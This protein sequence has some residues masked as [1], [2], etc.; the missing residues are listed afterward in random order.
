MPNAM[1][2][3]KIYQSLDFLGNRLLNVKVNTPN[4]TKNSKDFQKPEYEEEKDFV[5][6]KE[7]VDKVNTYDSPLVT[8]HKSS[9]IFKWVQNIDNLTI[10]EVLEK[11]LFPKQTALYEDPTIN[12]VSTV[13][14]DNIPKL[15]YNGKIII[16][17]DRSN[18][19]IRKYRVR[20]KLNQGDRVSGNASQLIF[21]LPDNTE[22]K[23][24]SATD[25]NETL[26]V[27]EFEAALN[28]K[29]KVT[30]ERLYTGTKEIKKDSYG[31]PAPIENP[32]WKFTEDITELFFDKNTFQFKP[33]NFYGPLLTDLDVAETSE[34]LMNA[35]NY[36]QCSKDTDCIFD[37]LC[38]KNTL[39]FHIK[40]Y[41]YN[42]M[43]LV[44]AEKSH[45]VKKLG[46]SIT[47]DLKYGETL[48]YQ[49]YRIYL[50]NFDF[51]V[52]AYIFPISGVV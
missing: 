36:F 2:I 29:I 12:R 3:K 45:S 51:D 37:V 18:T 1:F 16:F 15:A 31:N 34:N 44:F 10:K 39:I 21:T 27:F 47:K 42:S 17:D 40:I 41:K 48:E 14:D 23:R 9:T 6:N 32:N 25:T 13:F 11:L 43:E 8:K 35:Q 4:E 22:L 33:C 52:D 50:G 20:I 5:A 19:L 30:F 38:P 28:S 7:Y 49:K 46:I 26:Q 24:V